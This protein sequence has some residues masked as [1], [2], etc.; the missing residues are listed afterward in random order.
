MTVCTMYRI[1]KTF[2]DNS[3]GERLRTAHTDNN[4][5]VIVTND[6]PLLEA[7]YHWFVV[8]CS[9]SRVA[10]RATATTW[11]ATAPRPVLAAY[12]QPIWDARAKRWRTGAYNDTTM[13]WSERQVTVRRKR[14]VGCLRPGCEVHDAVPSLSVLPRQM[15]AAAYRNPFHGGPVQYS[16]RDA[17]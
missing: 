7:G 4:P 10:K 6:R 9:W 15:R 5:L 8:R 13:Q 16:P 2:E 11:V 1:A 14:A 17:R 12:S 3:N